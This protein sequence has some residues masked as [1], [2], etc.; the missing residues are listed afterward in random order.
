[1]DIHKLWPRYGVLSLLL[2][3]INGCA[4]VPDRPA[5]PSDLPS[6]AYYE[7]LYAGDPEN[8]KHQSREE[9]LKWVKAFYRGWGGLR[10]WN[11]IMNEILDDVDEAEREALRRELDKLGRLISGEW[12]KAY[13]ERVIDSNMLQIWINAA[14][15]A[16]ERHDY[17]RLLKKLSTDVEALLGDAMDPSAITLKRYYPDAAQPPPFKDADVNADY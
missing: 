7:S 9:Y 16:G 5:W 3:F 12:A 10:G 17:Q 4:V 11:S 8:R 15:E 6:L 1:M 2:F 14:Y 13:G